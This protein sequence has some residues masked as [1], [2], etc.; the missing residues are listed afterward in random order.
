MT[1]DPKAP[2]APAVYLFREETTD[3]ER[4][5]WTMYAR[6]KILKKEGIDKFADVT[7]PYTENGD[8]LDYGWTESVKGVEAR[9]IH[10]D[11]TVVPFAG[12]PWT[13]ELVKAGGVRV[14]EKGFSMPDVQVGSILE[15][16]YEFHFPGENP[17][18]WYIQQPLFVHKAHYHYATWFT[19]HEQVLPEN[20]QIIQ[21]PMKDWDLVLPDIPALADEDDSPPAHA[22]GY[23]VY[24]YYAAANQ[25]DVYWQ[26]MGRDWGNAVDQFCNPDKVKNAVAQIIAP[27][28][29]DE[30]KLRR[31]Y[32]ATMK[33]ENTDFTRE[34]TKAENKAEKLKVRTA[35]DIWGAQRGT[36]DDIALLFIAMARAAGLKAYAMM[37]T[38]RDRDVFLKARMDWNQLD[39]IIAIVN[40]AGKEM[41][42]DPGQRYCE[43]GK[44]HWKHTWT[45]GVRQ[46]DKGGAI[47]EGTPFPVYSDTA[48][49][50]NANLGMDADGQ[51]QG[52]IQILMTG[53][54]A[55]RWRQEA[56]L[57]DE[58]QTKEEFVSWL[59]PEL[60]AGTTVKM[61]AFAGLTDPSQPLAAT[62]E[63]SGSMG[64]KTG[65][66][67][68]L[69][70]TFFEAQAKAR[71]VSGTRENPVYLPYS[72]T[73][74]DK[75]KISLPAN[76]TVE[77]VP[78][79][80]QI[81]FTPNADFEAK[82]RGAANLYQ[83]V[84]LERIAKILYEK[85]DYPGL[86]DFFQKMNTQDQDQL[87]L[88]GA[89]APAAG[90]GARG[91]ER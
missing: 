70:G 5:M 81:P 10:S 37:V 60:P 43:F 73:V 18:H 27:G 19:Q 71:F 32:A 68:F 30:Q 51:V 53:S 31:I 48:T 55:L 54:A 41:Y 29:T 90:N 46:I 17:P 89:A 45:T 79:D 62:L 26:V 50:R 84:R 40:L 38:D 61:D 64:S 39:D 66:R 80:A 7:I 1:S 76:V 9:T 34:R 85:A 74:Q 65:K 2:G 21:R 69:P 24:F 57:T 82:Y 33:L 59:Q 13:K 78:K 42:F 83:Y 56:L 63:V 25:A 87:V 52:K 22:L 23:H 35:A 77:N 6:I 14:M 8:W 20:A 88:T 28:D 72:Y 86:R 3:D 16:R 49:M 75:V 11:G 44:L 15:Y 4:H 91:G 67:I 12:K 36:S 47:L 58:P